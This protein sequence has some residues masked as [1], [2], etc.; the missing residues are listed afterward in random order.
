MKQSNIKAI[1]FSIIAFLL[2]TA[3][4]SCAMTLVIFHLTNK[5]EQTTTEPSDTSPDPYTSVMPTESELTPETSPTQ[6]ETPVEPSTEIPPTSQTPIEELPYVLKSTSDAGIAYQ[7]SLIF[8]GDSTS[9]G[10]L[11]NEVLTGG[12]NTR[13]VWYGQNGTLYL[14]NATENLI[15]DG[16]GSSGKML[17]DLVAEKRPPVIV[18]TLGVGVSSS[19]NEGRFSAFY[20]AVIQTILSKSPSTK[21]ICNSMYPVCEVRNADYQ[22]LNNNDIST[23]NGWILS[24]VQS[25]YN[26]GEQVYYLDSYSKLIGNDGYMPATYSNGDGLHLSPAGFEIVLSNIRTHKIPD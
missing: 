18:V 1:I 3:V 6:S 9:Y 15:F 25:H 2:L 21:I 10:M 20:D 13:Q 11:A 12:K 24:L 22:L 17:A 8:L 26:K 4:L 16:N 7:D 19:F 14:P 23:A 5:P